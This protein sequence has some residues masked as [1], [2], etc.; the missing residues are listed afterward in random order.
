MPGGWY[1]TL[2]YWAEEIRISHTFFALPFALA[3]MAVASHDTR[4]WPGIRPFLLILVCL[5]TARTCAMIFNRWADVEFDRRNPRTR[6]RHLASGRL[7]LRSAVVLW[8]LSATGFLAASWHINRLCFLLSPLAL[9][10]VCLYSLTKRFT[11]FTHL[12]L[13]AALA[14]AP[15]GAWMAVTGGIDLLPVVLALAVFCWLVGFDMIYAIQDHEFDRREGLGSLIV[16]WGVANALHAAFISHVLMLLLLGVV[17]LLLRYRYQCFCLA[18]IIGM[19][20][21]TACLLFEHW[22]ARR[23]SLRWIGTAFFRL[24]A[25]ISCLFLVVVTVEISFPFFEDYFEG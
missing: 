18:Y 5:I 13:G 2:R 7:S 4:G 10:A 9:V 25:L 1:R 23:R 11:D 22:L 20:L 12:Y 21:I 17:G 6:N 3:S 24:N 15:L 8:C 19:L 14:L 16:R